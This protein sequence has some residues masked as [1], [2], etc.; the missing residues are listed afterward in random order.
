MRPAVFGVT[1]E[2]RFAVCGDTST[3]ELVSS[4]ASDLLEGIGRQPLR[5]LIEMPWPFELQQRPG[6]DLE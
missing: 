3:L 5:G 6:A 4:F 2:T 1:R